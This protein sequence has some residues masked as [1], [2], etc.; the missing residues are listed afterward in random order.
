V[1]RATRGPVVLAGLAAFAALFA[2]GLA[3]L[4]AAG[5][6]VARYPALVA[7]GATSLRHVTDVVSAVNFDFRALDTLGEELILFTAVL[8]V[9]TIL[10]AHRGAQEPRPREHAHDAR[11]L[12]PA[13]D[14]L[15]VAGVVLIAVVL[16]VGLYVVTHGHLT[17]GGGFQ[18][19]VILAAG[20]LLVFLGG[21]VVVARRLR[22]VHAMEL[23]HAL[24]AGGFACLGLAP[25]LGGLAFFENFL[26]LG[27]QSHL[28][29]G[30]TIPLGNV[31][32]GT[33][34]AG[35]FVLLFSELLAQALIARG[36]E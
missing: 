5:H 25:L 1:S 6:V 33:E 18:G 17:P 26:P 15:R 8:G 28:L 35:A 34:V 11:R 14:A 3:G 23:V 2:W 24:G 22:P 12:P 4:P 31:A 32:V 13:S 20:F 30:G 36:D 9:A 29:S 16:L 10:R 19:G 21:E 27:V 7:R